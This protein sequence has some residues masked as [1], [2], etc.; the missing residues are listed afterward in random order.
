[1]IGTGY[2][3]LVSGTCFADIGI[4]S[5]AVTSMNQKIN[6]LKSGVVPIYEPGLK[7]LI[8]KNTEEGRLFFTTN[9]PRYQGIR[10]YLYCCR[11]PMTAQEKQ[12]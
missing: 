7:E 1:M 8:E 5:S 2:V 6:S 10:H 4:V 3:G 11:D 9:I 12:I